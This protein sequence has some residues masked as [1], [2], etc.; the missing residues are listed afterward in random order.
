MNWFMTSLRSSS[1]LK[2]PTQLGVVHILP[3]LGEQAAAFTKCE[4][5]MQKTFSGC[6]WLF[7][8]SLLGELLLLS[9][10]STAAAEF[11]NIP[12]ADSPSHQGCQT[13]SAAKSNVANTV[14][15][16]YLI[17]LS[18]GVHDLYIN[19]SFRNTCLSSCKSVA[20]HWRQALIVWAV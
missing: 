3:C 10:I 7:A 8:W 6:G 12:P 9:V 19:V 13:S 11:F 4:F 17:L 20:V 2:S 1:W 14:Q 16:Q 5:K 15:I 18:I